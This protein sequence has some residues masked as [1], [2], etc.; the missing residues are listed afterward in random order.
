MKIRDSHTP[1]AYSE[2]ESEVQGHMVM[3]ALKKA[4]GLSH[5]FNVN[6]KFLI[7]QCQIII[8]VVIW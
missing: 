1:P 5:L 6:P 2:L 8:E 4:L 7:K 3:S